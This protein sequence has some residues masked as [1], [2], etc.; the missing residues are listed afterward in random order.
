MPTVTNTGFEDKVVALIGP[1]V[2]VALLV[3]P[4]SSSA[5]FAHVTDNDLLVLGKALGVH[6][7]GH[8]AFSAGIKISQMEP[9]IKLNHLEQVHFT[10]TLNDSISGFWQY[11]LS[12]E[13]KFS[14]SGSFQ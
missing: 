11:T 9:E 4:S 14:S 2:S 12:K 7:A 13:K 10:A 1:D 8:R 5:S 3:V 6:V